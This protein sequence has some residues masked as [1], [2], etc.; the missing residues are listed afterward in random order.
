MQGGAWYTL[1]CSVEVD[2]MNVI[3]CTT[4]ATLPTDWALG[5]NGFGVGAG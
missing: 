5:Y 2:Q 1:H 3:D 4:H